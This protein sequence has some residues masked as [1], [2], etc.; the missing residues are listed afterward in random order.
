MDGEQL[1]IVPI[2]EAMAKAEAAELDLVEIAPMAKP[3]VCRIMDYGKFKYREAKKQHEA[4]LKLKQIQVK[5]VKFRPG[6]DEGDYRIKLR[7]LT[8]F[9]AEGDKAKV[10]L[11]FRGREMAHQEFGVRLL[12]RIRG[13]LEPVAIVEQFPR[14]EGRQMVML[15]A[16]K[17]TLPKPHH[18]DKPEAGPPQDPQA[19]PAKPERTAVGSK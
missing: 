18:P 8:R 14:L 15:L 3:P 13:D 11:R 9:L 10:T 12:E 19:A 17:K 4:K 16:P 5:E 7:N 6:T 1:G 2:A